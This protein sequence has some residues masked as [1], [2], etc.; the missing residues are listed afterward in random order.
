MKKG[1]CIALMV[2][3]SC[4]CST[5][6]LQRGQ[7][8]YDQGY[9][10]ARDGIVVAEYTVGKD[11]TVPRD[12]KLAEERFKRRRRTVE[13]CYKQM[14]RMDERIEQYPQYL[15]LP[16]RALFSVLTTPWRLYKEYKYAHD[17]NYR[18][19][20]DA[21]EEKKDQ[22][23]QARVKQV[24]QGLK[25]YLERDLKAESGVEAVPA[26]PEEAALP[27]E[28]GKPATAEP[29]ADAGLTLSAG[30]A[31]AK[32]KKALRQR[33]PRQRQKPIEKKA[34]RAESAHADIKAVIV[35]RPA[36]GY[37]PL[38]VSFS[39]AGSSSRAGKIIACEWDFGDGDKSSLKSPVNTYYSASSQPRQFPVTVTVRDSKGNTASS[40]VII[41]VLNK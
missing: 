7:K 10:M 1:I 36:R 16:F 18:D 28:S 5:Y 21:A 6:K 4:G 38:K 35:A 26:A 41:E 20:V 29:A 40:S 2:L 37:S 34:A 25:A 27:Q 33:Q 23:E 3:L 22:I 19:A 12:K 13:R 17:K 32:A 39:C 30:P 24:E 8:P 11:N 14:G 9:V 15:L 31:P